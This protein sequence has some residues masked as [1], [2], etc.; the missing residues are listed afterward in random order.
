VDTSE[1]EVEAGEGKQAKAIPTHVNRDCSK[2][3]R[4]TVRHEEDEKCH[5]SEHAKK[6]PG[7]VSIGLTGF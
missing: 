4:L 2:K 5:F 6:R 7:A 1:K 3:K